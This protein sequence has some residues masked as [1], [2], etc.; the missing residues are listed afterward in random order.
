LSELLSKAIAARVGKDSAADLPLKESSG[1]VGGPYSRH[2]IVIIM[3]VSGSG[4][5]TVGSLLAGRLGWDFRDGDDF[6]PPANVA[7]MRSGTPLTD[8]D[9]FPWLLAIQAFMRKCHADGQSAVI[10]CSALKESYRDV[11]LRAQSWVRFVHLSGSRELIALRMQARSGHFMPPTL[12][13]SQ[14]ATLEPPADALS[15]DI[16]AAPA[17]LVEGICQQLG[18]ASG[19]PKA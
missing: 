18:L 5:T 1:G 2:M 19:S 11:L 8:E 4:K 9:R 12:L 15:A 13:D 10:A 3:G 16:S 14:L 17:D 6:H 7:K